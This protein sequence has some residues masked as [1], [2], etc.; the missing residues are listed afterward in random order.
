MLGI[1]DVDF[2]TAG[3]Q[4]FDFSFEGVADPQTIVRT[5]DRALGEKQAAGGL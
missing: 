1:G 5:V 2:D 4:G 3:E